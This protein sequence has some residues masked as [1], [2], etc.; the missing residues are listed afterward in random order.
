MTVYDLSKWRGLTQALGIILLIVAIEF[1]FRH[2]VFFWFPQIGSLRVN[3]MLCLLVAYLVLTGGLGLIIHT[4]W[5]KEIPEIWKKLYE[6]MM[7]WH[8]VGWVAMM[9]LSLFVLPILDRFISRMISIPF[10]LS[11]YR[12]TTVWLVEH[13]LILKIIS[14]I[15][16]NGLFIPVAEEFLWRGLVQPRLIQSI[17][18]FLGISTTAVLFSLKHVL[19]DASFARF[20]T[21]VAFGAITGALAYRESWRSSAALHI[22]INTVATITALAMGQ[23]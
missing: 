16:I 13:A 9:V 21:I 19:I 20:L 5:C 15:S 17:G 10:F 1:F 2:Y 7:T 18:V 6:L 14:L 4:V 11:T 3:D 8:Y 22:F 23:M 12:N